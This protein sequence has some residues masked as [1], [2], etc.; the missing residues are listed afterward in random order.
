[1]SSLPHAI[2]GLLATLLP[3][4]TAQGQPA[5]DPGSQQADGARAKPGMPSSPEDDARRAR[6]CRKHG[7]IDV[8]HQG[9]PTPGPNSMDVVIC[10]RTDGGPGFS[11]AYIPQQRGQ[12]KISP[13]VRMKIAPPADPA[14]ARMPP[15]H[16]DPHGRA[17]D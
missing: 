17:S 9:E 15:L 2:I 12:G 3:L 16:Q 14:P 11:G 4:A 13:D 1:M 6:W 5:P 7:G 10:Q 8:T